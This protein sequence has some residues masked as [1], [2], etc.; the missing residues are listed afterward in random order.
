MK[1]SDLGKR[2]REKI[3]MAMDSFCLSKTAKKSYQLV[4][5]SSKQWALIDTQIPLQNGLA[6]GQGFEPWVPFSTRHFECRTIDLSDNP[7]NIGKS[8][9]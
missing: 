4:T 7:P 1:T 3:V 5:D 8:S 2:G 6:E 9:M